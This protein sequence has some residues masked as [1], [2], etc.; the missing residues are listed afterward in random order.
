MLWGATFPMVKRA[1]SDAPPLLFNLLRMSLAAAILAAFHRRRLGRL[2]WRRAAAGASAGLLLGAGYQLQTAGLAFTSPTRSAFL[3]GLTVL[4]VPLLG[5]APTLLGLPG[6]RL[7][8]PNL[9]AALLALAGIAL[10]TPASGGAARGVLSAVNRGDL[11]SLLCAVAFALHLLALSRIAPGAD[12]RALATVQVAAAA[13][14][15]L[16]TLPLGGAVTLRPSPWLLGTLLVTALLAT[17][18]AFTVQTW[19][20]QQLPAAHVALLLTLEPVFALLT[21]V[22]FFGERLSGRAL[23]GAGLILAGIATAEWLGSTPTVTR[24]PAT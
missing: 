9:I 15:M 10:L 8:T 16:L 11:L 5:A 14:L 24:G 21:S 22:L 20:Q 6:H 13:A 17:A 4:F 12:A 1:L 23:L 2:G 18:A 7:R 3:T 19:V